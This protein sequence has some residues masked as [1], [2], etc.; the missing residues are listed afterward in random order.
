MNG[1]S[2]TPKQKVNRNPQIHPKTLI[3]S[4][5]LTCKKPN[6]HRTLQMSKLIGQLWWFLLGDRCP[7]AYTTK[8]IVTFGNSGSSL[9]SFPQNPKPCCK[10]KYFFCCCCMKT[11]TFCFRMTQFQ[12]FSKN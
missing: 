9:T 4:Y 11:D 6:T 1:S 8:C 3:S 2:D 7:V 5:K 12:N 10:N